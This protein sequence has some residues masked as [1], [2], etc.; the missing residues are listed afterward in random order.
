MPAGDPN[1]PGEIAAR[2]VEARQALAAAQTQA[3]QSAAAVA[4]ATANAQATDR[5]LA[6]A[7]AATE[8][9]FSLALRKGQA[10]ETAAAQHAQSTQTAD[11]LHA[12]ATATALSQAATAT[13]ERQ[14]S[15][16][17]AIAQRAAATADAYAARATA[18]A[19]EVV[20]SREIASATTDARRAQVE[21]AQAQASADIAIARD[22]A[23]SS[24]VTAV[25]S[26]SGL[27]L[28]GGIIAVLLGFGQFVQARW[29]NLHTKLVPGGMIVITGNNQTGYTMRYLPAPRAEAADVE[30]IEEGQ[31]REFEAA[32]A[33]PALPELDELPGDGEETLT[34]KASQV[35][36]TPERRLALR[37]LRHAMHVAGPQ[38]QFIPS[39]V[40]LRWPS[41]T[42]QRAV[43]LLKPYLVTKQG[44]NGG[45]FVADEY[46][47]L[48][49]LYTA[50]RKGK[51]LSS[52]GARGPAPPIRTVMRTV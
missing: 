34:P 39:A 33:Q 13:A 3:A 46:G 49:A 27:V 21:I 47:S 35:R 7:A 12:A 48:S 25:C 11:A 20:A 52:P 37:L 1:S 19:R 32:A 9:A 15:E 6:N 40:A 38:A 24:V 42:R 30:P 50:V 8:A 4:R 18:D 22:Q 17:T 44:R 51:P 10:T 45:T 31:S 23:I 26:L 36:E 16:A 41:E 5:A 43:N 28:L 29:G 14:S 2:N